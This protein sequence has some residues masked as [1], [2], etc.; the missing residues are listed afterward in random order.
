MKKVFYVRAND[1]MLTRAMTGNNSVKIYSVAWERTGDYYDGIGS[2]SH[3]EST[4]NSVYSLDG[5]RLQQPQSG[6]NIVRSTEG[7]SRKYMMK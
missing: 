7:K 6:V 1:E 2:V 4:V 5:R 3:N